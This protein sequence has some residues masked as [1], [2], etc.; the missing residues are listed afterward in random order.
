MSGQRH[1][2]AALYRR[3][4]ICGTRWIGGWVGLR[5]FLDT[6][7]RGKI[8]CLCRGSNPDLPVVQPV[9]RHCTD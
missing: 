2:T 1:A 8:I 9:V 3:E 7:A 6:D 5:A 4:I